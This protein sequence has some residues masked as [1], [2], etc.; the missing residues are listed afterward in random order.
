MNNTAIRTVDNVINSKCSCGKPLI[1][2]F[3]LVLL[4]P[5]EHLM[6]I[7]CLRRLKFAKCLICYTNIRRVMT[8]EQIKHC[9]EHKNGQFIQNYIDMVSV[10]NFM[11]NTEINYPNL[12]CRAPHSM[13][14]INNFINTTREKEAYDIINELFELIDL[15]IIV[16]NKHLLNIN[17]KKVYIANHSS[18]IDPV[19]LYMIVRCGFVSSDVIKNVWYAK[20]VPDILPLVLISRGKD[21]NTV[22]KIKEYLDTKRSVCL[23]PEGMINHQD[24]LINFRTGAFVTGYPIQPMIIKYYPNVYDTDP[25]NYLSKLLSQDNLRVEVTVMETEYP[26]FDN[27]KIERIRQKMA[28]IGNMYL[29]RVSNR[30]VID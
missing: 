17:E 16:K 30:D 23:F 3:K 27:N 9:I 20:H 1:S 21:K 11:K 28:K 14:L 13:K 19:I 8:F 29:S 18:Y 5:C 12:L 26:P 24:T 7:K 6:H 22:E 25:T 4:L 2:D 15:K 10:S